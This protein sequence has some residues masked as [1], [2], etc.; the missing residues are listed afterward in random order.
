MGAINP[1]KVSITKLSK[2]PGSV[3]QVDVEGAI[4]EMFVSSAWVAD[5]GTVHAKGQL[6][7]VHSGILFSGTATIE[8]TSECRR[9]LGRSTQPMQ[10]E[11]R[12]LFEAD[13]KEEEG[14]TYPVEGDH[15]DLTEMLR[16]AVVLALPAAPLCSAEC[17]GLCQVCGTNLNETDCGHKGGGDIDPRFR[18]LDQLR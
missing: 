7:A 8:V 15:V 12:E 14:D 3:L 17:K 5:D 13:F 9:C 6:E 11:I 16:D 2:A 18:I 10:V 4:P 1:F